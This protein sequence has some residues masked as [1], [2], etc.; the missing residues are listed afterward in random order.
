MIGYGQVILTPH[1]AGSTVESARGIADDATKRLLSFFRTG[2]TI[3]SVN[4]P[5]LELA[6]VAEGRT[7]ILHVHN[8]V[9]G[10]NAALTRVL[11]EGGLN[12][13]KQQLDTVPR[14]GYAAVDVEGGVTQELEKKLRAVD[15][16]IRL[17]LLEAT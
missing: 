14:L 12:I 10:V 1:I 11:Q 2:Q 17:R 7:R 8:N 16:T 5:E 9:P 13:A 4:F 6:N 15:Q 3:G